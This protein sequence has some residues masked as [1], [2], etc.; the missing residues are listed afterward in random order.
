MKY[1]DALFFLPC[2]LIT[3]AMELSSPSEFYMAHH[4]L[5]SEYICERLFIKAKEINFLDSVTFQDPKE[6]IVLFKI[7]KSLCLLKLDENKKVIATFG[8]Q[9]R[10]REVHNLELR[11]GL[12]LLHK[13]TITSAKNFQLARSKSAKILRIYQNK[14]CDRWLEFDT[15]GCYLGNFALK[16]ERSCCCC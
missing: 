8:Q 5:V 13:L 10:S 16:K 2:Y 6:K 14:Q 15:D 9:Q 12:I 7:K 1:T 11:E 4:E 3:T